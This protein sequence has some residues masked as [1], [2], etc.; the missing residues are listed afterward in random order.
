MVCCRLRECVSDWSCVLLSQSG[1]RNRKSLQSYGISNKIQSQFASNLSLLSSAMLL[2]SLKRPE[3]YGHAPEHHTD[4]WYHAIRQDKQK[5]VGTLQALVRHMSS[6]WKE[7]NIY[8]DLG[9]CHIS[10][11]LGDP[12]VRGMAGHFLQIKWQIIVSCILNY[13]VGN[14]VPLQLL[15]FLKA[16]HSSHEN[17]DLVCILNNIKSCYLWLELEQKRDM[18]QVQA[19]I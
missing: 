14:T 11:I 16:T 12:V 13:K 8:E 6:R 10:K 2:F 4:Q 19:M 5:V 3:S 18:K 9:I 7:E 1:K 17:T 15:K